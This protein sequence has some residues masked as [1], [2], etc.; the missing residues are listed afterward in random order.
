MGAYDVHS[1]TLIGMT[2]ETTGLV[3]FM[4]LVD[5]VMT[6][7]PYANARCVYW[8]VDHGSSHIGKRSIERMTAAWPNARLVHLPVHASWLNQIEIVFSIIQRKVVK[9]ADFADLGVLADRLCRFEDRY[10]QTASPFDWRFTRHDLTAMLQ[11]FD[12]Q[13][14]EPAIALA[15]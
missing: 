6:R 5:K 1:A 9:P 12:T 10:N 14:T 7:E 13:P 8:V 2:A 11:R 3:P 15:A 4:E